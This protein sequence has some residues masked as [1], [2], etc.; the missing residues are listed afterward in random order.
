MARKHSD[1]AGQEAPLPPASE[2][3]VAAYLKTNPDFLSRH[4]ELI[5]RMAPPT[6]FDGGPVVDLQQYMIARLHEEMAQLRG[7]A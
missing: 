5:A 3:Q 4:P 7:C 2:E 6:R 1:V